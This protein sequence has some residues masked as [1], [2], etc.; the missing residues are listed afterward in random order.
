MSFKF[1]GTRLALL[2]SEAFGKNFE[3]TIDGIKVNSIELKAIKNGCG[4][5]YISELLEDKEHTVV[6]RCLGEANIDS[7]VIYS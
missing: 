4:V 7:V 3:V 6:I 2:S 5:S 1:N